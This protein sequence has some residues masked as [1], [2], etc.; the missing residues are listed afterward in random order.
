MGIVADS[1]MTG[2]SR[3]GATTGADG[4]EGRTTGIEDTEGRTS[5]S[6]K[7]TAMADLSL[8]PSA[9]SDNWMNETHKPKND[10]EPRGYGLFALRCGHAG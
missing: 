10:A 8:A 2:L 4:T 5:R 7:F 6:T 3:L 9:K 1:A